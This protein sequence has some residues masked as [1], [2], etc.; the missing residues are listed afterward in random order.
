[1]V[2][3]PLQKPPETLQASPTGEAAGRVSAPSDAWLGGWARSR[4]RD[5]RYPGPHPCGATLPCC[6]CCRVGSTCIMRRFT[7]ATSTQAAAI[8]IGYAVPG[9]R[10]P[11]PPE[12]SLCSTPCVAIGT[13]G[14]PC[15]QLIE[16]PSQRLARPPMATAHGRTRKSSNT[17]CQKC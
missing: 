10:V 2:L 17:H 9:P 16:Q 15:L 3:T 12:Q 13:R 11:Q 7:R 4:G 1:M 6:T 8:G 14:T 5:G